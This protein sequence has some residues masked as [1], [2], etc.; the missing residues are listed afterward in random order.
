M[1]GSC[2]R[3]TGWTDS[4]VDVKGLLNGEWS[5]CEA[6]TDQETIR[7]VAQQY[8]AR[9]PRCW[10][11]DDRI[12]IP[13]WIVEHLRHNRQDILLSPLPDEKQKSA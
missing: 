13:I 11:V 5:A 2:H 12:V 4:L 8:H 1:S 7:V 9:H 10:V 3:C 6:C